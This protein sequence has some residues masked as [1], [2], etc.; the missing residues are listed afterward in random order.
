MGKKQMPLT[1]L[2]ANKKA[3]ITVLQG[4]SRFHQKLEI[5]GIREGQTIRMISKQ[6]LRGPL[7]VEVGGSQVTIGRGMAQKIIVEEHD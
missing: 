7:T 5:I 3:R 2:S 1:Q 6:P 4:G